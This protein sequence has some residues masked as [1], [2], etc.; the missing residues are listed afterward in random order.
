MISADIIKGFCRKYSK[1]LRHA[2]YRQSYP[3]KAITLFLSSGHGALTMRFGFIFLGQIRYETGGDRQRFPVDGW[4][5]LVIG[6]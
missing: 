4:L 2:Y 3:A 1:A 6:L 5:I